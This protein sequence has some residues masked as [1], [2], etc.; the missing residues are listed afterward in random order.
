MASKKSI[1]LLDETLEVT[2]FYENKDRDL[3]DNICMVIN[4]S[5]PEDEKIFKHDESHLYFTRE[6]ALELAQAFIAA[7]ERSESATE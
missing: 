5:C 7:V 3:R 1:Y 2:I 4:E 6:Q